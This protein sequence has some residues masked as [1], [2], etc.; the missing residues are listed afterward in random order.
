[1]RTLKTNNEEKTLIMNF[2]KFLIN[3]ANFKEYLLQKI[4]ELIQNDEHLRQLIKNF[5]FKFIIK[6]EN[7]LVNKLMTFD[8][9]LEAQPKTITKKIIRKTKWKIKNGQTLKKNYEE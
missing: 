8:L 3:E 7:L 2:E 6:M 5:N 4:R 1:M 9:I